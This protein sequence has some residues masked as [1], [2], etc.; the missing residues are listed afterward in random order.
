MNLILLGALDRVAFGSMD[1]AMTVF[2]NHP[3][4]PTTM[5]LAAA[6]TPHP[7]IPGADIIFGAI[8]G[9]AAKTWTPAFEAIGQRLL[10][11]LG[12][13]RLRS[14]IESAGFSTL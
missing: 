14:G 7:G 2:G 5:L 13:G 4:H 8:A 11:Y 9:G 12:A 10:R 6:L 3:E 1:V